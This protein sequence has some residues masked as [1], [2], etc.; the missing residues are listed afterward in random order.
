MRCGVCCAA[1]DEQ[2]FETLEPGYRDGPVTPAMCGMTRKQNVIGTMPRRTVSPLQAVPF[3]T[4]VAD[5][6]DD[7]EGIAANHGGPARGVRRRRAWERP[8]IRTA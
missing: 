2:C 1:I 3:D 4:L 5:R 8:T 7:P 6:H